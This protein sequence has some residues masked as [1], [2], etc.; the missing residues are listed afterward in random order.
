MELGYSERLLVGMKYFRSYLT[1]RAS[2]KFRGR[3]LA[4][5]CKYGKANM[6]ASGQNPSQVTSPTVTQPGSNS[7]TPRT[8]HNVRSEDY[9]TTEILQNTT[10][11]LLNEL[12]Y[13]IY[14][15]Y[16]AR[17]FRMLTGRH[18]IFQ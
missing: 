2:F 10:E 14:L 17:L 13:S 9:Y 12:F 15:R 1:L 3:I 6:L 4:V 7:S 8:S 5:T 18:E 16:G 11:I